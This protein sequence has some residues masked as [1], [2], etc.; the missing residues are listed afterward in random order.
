MPPRPSRR[1]PRRSQEAS[2][3][4]TYKGPKTPETCFARLENARDRKNPRRLH[5]PQMLKQVL[6]GP[7]RMVSLRPLGRFG[8]IRVPSV[9]RTFSVAVTSEAGF[10][11]SGGPGGSLAISLPPPSN[12]I[13]DLGGGGPGGGGQPDVSQAFQPPQ[14]GVGGS[15]RTAPSLCPSFFLLPSASSHLHLTPF[16]LFARSARFWRVGW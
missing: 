1:P 11:C 3:S 16:I 4:L 8:A 12:G 5:R 6:P 9:E 13:L 7:S 2:R 15:H 14:A 10:G